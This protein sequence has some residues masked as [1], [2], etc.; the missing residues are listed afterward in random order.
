M[1]VK[2]RLMNMNHSTYTIRS[3]NECCVDDLTVG[4]IPTSFTISYFCVVC[5]SCPISRK[6]CPNT[7]NGFFTTVALVYLCI[8]SNV[9]L[10]CHQTKMSGI[11]SG[12]LQ[13]NI[14][15]N[16][17][18]FIMSIV[19]WPYMIKEKQEGVFKLIK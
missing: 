16:T 11:P 17:S 9:T 1:I 12:L 8:S 5:I 18:E 4:C 10:L 14:L 13:M 6:P 2:S 15:F 3:K 7:M 19:H